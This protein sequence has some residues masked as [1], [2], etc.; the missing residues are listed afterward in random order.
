MLTKLEEAIFRN[1]V[2][3]EPLQSESKHFQE[4]RA[5]LFERS[6]FCSP[7]GSVCWSALTASLQGGDGTEF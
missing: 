1:E 5:K 6:E 7:P 2:T 4:K 3:S